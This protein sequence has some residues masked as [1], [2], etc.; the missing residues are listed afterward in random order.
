MLRKLGSYPQ[1]NGLAI[2]L[3]EL[4]RIE[5]KLFILIM[6]TSVQGICGAPNAKQLY[7]KRS[8]N[9]TFKVIT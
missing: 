3:R 9:P 2:A 1:Q 6:F 5:R 7:C 4:N 8:I